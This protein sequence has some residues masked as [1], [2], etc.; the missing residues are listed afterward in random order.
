MLLK[1][2]GVC[3]FRPMYPRTSR[4]RGTHYKAVSGHGGLRCNALGSLRVPAFTRENWVSK[5]KW[6]APGGTDSQETNWKTW[7]LKHH[8]IREYSLSFYRR[9]YWG[10]ERFHKP[11]KLQSLGISQDLWISLLQGGGARALPE[12]R[13]ANLQHQHLWA[14]MRSSITM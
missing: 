11:R 5:T 9:G 10:S 12:Q 7:A 6:F 8:T 2:S 13:E 4:S 14:G 1:T 3:R